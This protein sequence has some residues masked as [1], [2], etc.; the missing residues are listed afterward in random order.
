[1]R[2]REVKAARTS[3]GFACVTPS[4]FARGESPSPPL[5][6]ASAQ[7]EPG[8]ASVGETPQADGRSPYH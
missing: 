2:R 1:M 3:F 5:P 6:E 8:S 4:A 7:E